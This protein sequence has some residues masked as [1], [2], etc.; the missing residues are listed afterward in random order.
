MT[1]DVIGFIGNEWMCLPNNIQGRY[2]NIGRW[3]NI[4]RI[5]KPQQ[6]LN[7]Q[8]QQSSSSKYSHS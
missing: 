2:Q 4:T 5:L 7:H 6:E 1:L 8:Q 3:L